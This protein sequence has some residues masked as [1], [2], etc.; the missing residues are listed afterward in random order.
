VRRHG[1]VDAARGL[2]IAQ[3]VA[4]HLCYDLNHFSWIR[5]EMLVDPRWIAWRTAIVAQF[6]F[7]AGVSLALRPDSL[8]PGAAARFWR[9]W[10]QIAACAAAVS[11]ASAWLFGARWIWFGVLHFTALAQL[12][13]RPLLARNAAWWVG[14]RVSV[15]RP[16]HAPAIALALA[17]IGAVALGTTVHAAAF[18]PDALSW[19]GFAP[20]KP[21]TEDFVP[22]LPWL[23]PV[24]LG[25]AAARWWHQS[26]GAPA[27]ALRRYRAGSSRLLGAL[28]AAGRWPLTIYM[29]HQPLLFGALAVVAAVAPHGA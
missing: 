8:V 23:G 28:E 4:Y 25:A 22:V 17:G 10:G 20:V 19:I 5:V 6:L 3:M 12:L 24:L 21:A 2:A 18:A 15:R 9:R 14:V 1:V 11:L 7:L 13:L 27:S 26:T 16:V 29:V